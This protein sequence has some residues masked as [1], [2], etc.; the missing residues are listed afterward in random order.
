[1]AS[2][3]GPSAHT[4]TF[5]LDT[6]PHKFTLAARDP[7]KD[8][9]CGDGNLY[10]TAAAQSTTFK[11]L[12]TRQRRPSTSHDLIQCA[13]LIDSLD[14]V[15]EFASMVVPHDVPPDLQGLRALQISMSHSTKHF[16]GGGRLYR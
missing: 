4:D 11:D 1:M 15:H 13:R 2:M 14:T 3:L 8:I 12:E 6:L 7:E 16:L 10:F 9:I 5:A